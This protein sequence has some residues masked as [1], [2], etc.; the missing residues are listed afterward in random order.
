MKLRFAFLLSLPVLLA[1]QVWTARYNGPG[2]NRDEA[3][4]II[5]DSL[6]NV[7]IT[8]WS[9]HTFGF[10]YDYATI[11]YNSSGAQQWVAR[12][13]G[14]SDTCDQARAIG[15]D[16]SLN[17]YVTGRSF[18]WATN[19]DIVT[20][21]YNSQGDEQWVKRFNGS[22]NNDDQAYAMA[23]SPQ[24]NVYV[25]GY[26]YNLG[27]YWD[28]CL[29]K[30]NAQGESIWV[31][32]YN[33]TGNSND[34]I[35]ALAMDSMENC[36]VTGYS[37][38]VTSDYDIVTIKYNPDGE[39]VWVAR[40]DGPGHGFDQGFSIAI[41][42]AGEVWVTG[43]STDTT[44]Q[45]DFV[46]VHYNANGAQQWVARYH[47][48]GIGYDQAV[49]VAIDT[50]NNYSYITGNSLGTNNYFDIVTIAYD[51]DG[52][53]RWINRYDGLGNNIDN[54]VDITVDLFGNIC[55]AGY[56]QN[57]VTA[58]DWVTIKYNPLGDTCWLAIFDNNAFLDDETH[59]ITTD[60]S[61]YVYVTGYSMGVSSLRDYFVIKYYQGGFSAMQQTKA[62]EFFEN[63]P[64]L[65]PNPAKNF[66][67]VISPIPV[68]LFDVSG[69]L[70]TTLKP[71]SNMIKNLAKGIYF[72][73]INK[74]IDKIVVLDNKP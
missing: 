55:V 18:D 72:T 25:G 44:N 3:H 64:V 33:G 20:I 21:K 49:A 52:N 45:R 34:A 65:F 70:I 43:T 15:L 38:G 26:L 2:N 5:V 40:Y 9:P 11:K 41:N 14:P 69:K 63:Q 29:I 48:P 32:N 28:Y 37:V 66:V 42:Q 4:A 47:G 39:T 30:Y 56:S 68:K 8:G 71:G 62:G 31:A 24:G 58:H 1:A 46:T 16:E 22:A 10:S 61:G 59:A 73:N 7:Y 53:E 35:Y 12:Y 17:V 57:I 13:N 51:Q 67:K 23:V 74:K 6:Y 36:Y 27:T 54:A 50:S 60:D 19:N